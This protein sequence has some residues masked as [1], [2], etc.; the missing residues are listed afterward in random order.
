[1]CIL[2]PKDT[3]DLGL[4]GGFLRVQFVGLFGCLE[5]AQDD[6]GFVAILLPQLAEF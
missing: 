6:L 2:N 5:T 3:H 1:M 4:L